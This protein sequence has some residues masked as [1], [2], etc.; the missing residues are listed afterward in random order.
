MIENK[1]TSN[2]NKYIHLTHSGKV[3]ISSSPTPA[4]RVPGEGVAEEGG[5]V[6]RGGEGAQLLQQPHPSG[7]VEPSVRGASA[8][9]SGL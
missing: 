2:L 5:A 8:R 4:D 6:G 3:Y 9:S 7:V 1:Y